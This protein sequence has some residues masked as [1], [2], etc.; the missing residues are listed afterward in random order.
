MLLPFLCH[1]SLRNDPETPHQ[2]TRVSVCWPSKQLSLVFPDFAHWPALHV[3]CDCPRWLGMSYSRW[4]RTGRGGQAFGEDSLAAL[5]GCLV[6]NN[7]LFERIAE[8]LRA[9]PSGR[10]EWGRAPLG[11]GAV[12][13][14]EA[15]TPNPPRRLPGDPRGLPNPSLVLPSVVDRH[16]VL[17]TEC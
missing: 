11:A 8:I 1:C 2:K 9:T 16:A 12:P 14:S 3:L 17:N 4:E 10:G 13:C 15:N 7:I 5:R 6:N